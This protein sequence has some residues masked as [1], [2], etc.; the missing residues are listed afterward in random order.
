MINESKLPSN[1][2]ESIHRAANDVLDLIEDFGQQLDKRSPNELAKDLVSIRRQSN[3]LAIEVY[4][5]TFDMRWV[6][7]S[8]HLGT[9]V[10]RVQQACL[11]RNAIDLLTAPE[12][13][14]E[15]LRNKL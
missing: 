4:L 14:L 5:N 7:T 12:N 15:F 1:S 13:P 9:T 3:R 8:M 10:D 11:T 6:Q 2:R